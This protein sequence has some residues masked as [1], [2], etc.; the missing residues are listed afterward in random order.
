MATALAPNCVCFDLGYSYGLGPIAIVVSAGL[1][2]PTGHHCRVL[3]PRI[4]CHTI[5]FSGKSDLSGQ[6]RTIL[7]LVSSVFL[8]GLFS[9]ILTTTPEDFGVLL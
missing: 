8:A 6:Q 9:L 1:P 2:T 3:H 5:A 7:C 4:S